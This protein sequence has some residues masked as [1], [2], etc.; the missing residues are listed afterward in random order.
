[1][2]KDQKTKALF[3]ISEM[4]CERLWEGWCGE[5][6]NNWNPYAEDDEK[7]WCNPC[8]ARA[9]LAG[10]LPNPIVCIEVVKTAGGEVEFTYC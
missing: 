3:L 6:K 8:I 4:G 2:I 7:K 5:R 10:N 1:M 9:A